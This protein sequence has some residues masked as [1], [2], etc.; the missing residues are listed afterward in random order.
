MVMNF[1]EKMDAQM[2]PTSHQDRAIGRPWSSFLR[3]CEVLKG[4]FVFNELLVRQ[5]I[6]MISDSGRQIEKTRLV[7]EVSAGEAVC[8]GRD[9]VE[10]MLSENIQLR[11]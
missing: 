1:D 11:V 8:R 9:R 10:V 2:V 4:C 6:A 3:F 5:K 7:L